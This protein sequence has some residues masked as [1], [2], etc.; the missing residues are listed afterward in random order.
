VDK[1][2]VQELIDA[3]MLTPEQAEAFMA[4]LEA[5]APHLAEMAALG[6]IPEEQG[7]L[8]NQIGQGMQQQNI[9]G[10]TGQNVGRTYVASSPLE[11]LSVALQR[12][13]GG[14]KQREAEGQFRETLAQQ[15]KGRE[16]A[17]SRTNAL[18]RVMLMML[19][20]QQPQTPPV[21]G[22]AGWGNGY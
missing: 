15:T 14:M 4:Q 2:F 11:H 5:D 13:M 3:G 17:A 12:G 9:P 22:P 19:R 7:L 1:R 18:E 16:A 8:Q 10:A 21:Q 6:A 20:G